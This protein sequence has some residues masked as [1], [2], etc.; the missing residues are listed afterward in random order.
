MQSFLKKYLSG[1]SVLVFFILANTV[2][3]LMIGVTIPETMSYAGGK[4]LLDMM[5]LGYNKT[6]VAELFN[7]LGEEGRYVYLTHQL[8]LDFLYPGLFAI[9][10]CLIIAFLLDKI[11][12][13]ESSYILMC[14]LPIIAGFAD[15]MENFS[16]IILLS[17]FPDVSAML[18]QFANVFTILKSTSTTICFVLIIVLLIIHVIRKFK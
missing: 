18:V 5:P 12:K 17:K 4:P 10:Y 6:V 3:A 14:W 2:Y 13:L 15:Y 1:K 8:P 7:A 9:S 11:N 16:F